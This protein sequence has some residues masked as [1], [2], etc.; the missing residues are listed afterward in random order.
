MQSRKADTVPPCYKACS[1]AAESAPEG[2]ALWI[3]K[4]DPKGGSM[5]VLFHGNKGKHAQA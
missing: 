5:T 2:Y 1:F 4:T 3:T